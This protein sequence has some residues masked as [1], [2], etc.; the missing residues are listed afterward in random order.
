MCQADP[1]ALVHSYGRWSSFENFSI[2]ERKY[3]KFWTATED[4]WQKK[5]NFLANL[6]FRSVAKAGRNQED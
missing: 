5:N 2:T 3:Q 4:L 1:Q 6:Q